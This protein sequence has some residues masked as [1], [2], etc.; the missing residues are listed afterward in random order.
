METTP[1]NLRVILVG[2]EI[3]GWVARK[4][5]RKI[6]HDIAEQ[7]SATKD[8]GRFNKHLLPGEA[9]AYEA[10]HKKGRELRSF[11]YE[12]TLPWSKDGHR[13]LP[14]K[15]YEAFSEGV[16]RFK[17]EYANLA[18][19]FIRTYPLLKEDAK[20]L[21]NGMFR[22]SDYPR[23]EDMRGRFSIRLETLPF[24]DSGDFRV[25]LGEKEVMRI[26]EQIEARVKQE[27]NAA[28]QDLWSRLKTAV[29]NMV[30]R[31]SDP[32]GKFKDSL[33]GNLENI[34]ALIPKLNFT[35]DANLNEMRD[36]CE[37]SLIGVDAETLRTNPGVRARVAEDAR[38]IS[39]AMEYYM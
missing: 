37:G 39:S 14:T 28:N 31:L 35:E 1:L 12:N 26:R 32:D 7:H 24:P 23:P 34:V 16:R 27:I 33:V 10:V 9:E 15:N 17:R 25:S 8:A 6:S 11:Y 36:R 18:E 22:E 38:K 13:I 21:L 3:H 5:D 2:L 4:Y 20:I 30:L 29:D 19:Q